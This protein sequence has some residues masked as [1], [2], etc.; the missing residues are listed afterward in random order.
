MFLIRLRCN[1]HP[2]WQTFFITTWNNDNWHARNILIPT[3][4]GGVEFRVEPYATPYLEPE[5]GRRDYFDVP[6]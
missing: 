3:P 4:G 6:W 1:L 5:F 2:D